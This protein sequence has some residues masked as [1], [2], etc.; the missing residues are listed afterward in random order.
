[1][2]PGDIPLG[3]DTPLA[4]SRHETLSTW[5]NAISLR[6]AATA[7]GSNGA[8]KTRRL[9]R[10]S[11]TAWPPARALVRRSSPMKVGQT[12]QAAKE[13]PGLGLRV[14]RNEAASRRR[15]R[16]VERLPRV[17]GSLLDYRA[18]QT[19]PCSAQWLPTSILQASQHQWPS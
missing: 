7:T 4:P 13:R 3:V 16:T 14:V 1:M 12:C 5:A 11:R 17:V 2:R 10:P 9:V 18:R 19:G 15:Q 6:I 8:Q